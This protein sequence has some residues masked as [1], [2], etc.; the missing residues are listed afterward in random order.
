MNTG[1]RLV[2]FACACTPA[3]IW[4]VVDVPKAAATSRAVVPIVT[5]SS[6]TSESLAES[7]VAFG[8]PFGVTSE[9]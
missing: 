9:N 8:S 6:T 7:S 2:R 4:V 3:A 5:R 1:A